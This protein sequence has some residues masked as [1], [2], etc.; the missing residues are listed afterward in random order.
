MSGYGMAAF[1]GKD[2]TEGVTQS[3]NSGLNA[4]T[5][6]RL[7]EMKFSTIY[8][9]SLTWLLSNCSLSFPQ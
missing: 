9:Y 5:G 7:F 3:G 6:C 4:H 2:E 8:F 1:D